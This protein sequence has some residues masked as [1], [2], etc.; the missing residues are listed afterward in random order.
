MTNDALTAV[1]LLTSTIH[2]RST[3][4]ELARATAF[5]PEMKAPP[6]SGTLPFGHSTLARFCAPALLMKEPEV[7]TVRPRIAPWALAAPSV[8]RSAAATAS[9]RGTRSD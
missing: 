1:G 7:M 9:A 3:G 5:E 2:R 8:E 4:N 6:P